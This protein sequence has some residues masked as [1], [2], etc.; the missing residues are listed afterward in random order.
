METLAL[1]FA[2]AELRARRR[3]EAS[4]KDEGFFASQRWIPGL[5]SAGNL[6]WLGWHPPERDDSC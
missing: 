5:F 3:L 1:R 2:A 4:F 6:W